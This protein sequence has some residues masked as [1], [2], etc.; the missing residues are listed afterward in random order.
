MVTLTG[1]ITDVTGRA[2]DSISSITVKA[3]SARIGGGTDVIVSSPAKVA[4]DRTTGDV[5]ISGLTGGLSWLYIEGDGWSDSIPLA[6][7]EGFQLILEAIANASGVPGV[8]DYISM[9]R[10]S[11]THAQALARAAVEGEFG[12]VVRLTQAAATT[13][14]QEAT[15]ADARATYAE[16][17]A[18]N[19]V[20]R[21]EALETMAGLAPGDISDATMANI[22]LQENSLFRAVQDA[23]VGTIPGVVDDDTTDNTPAIQS[24]VDQGGRWM[25]PPTTGR[26]YVAGEVSLTV[27]GTELYAQGAPIRQGTMSLFRAIAPDLRIDGVDSISATGLPDFSGMT[28]PWEGTIS[29]SRWCVVNIYASA[30]RINIPWIRGRGMSSVV[31]SGGWDATTNTSTTARTDDINI[32][33]LLC[34]HVEFGTALKGTNRLHI[35]DIRGTYGDTVTAPRPPHLL[36]LAENHVDVTV[37]SA[38]A[39]DGVGG[40][41]HQIKQ[42]VGGVFGPLQATHCAGVLNL[43]DCADVEIEA[44]I[45]RSDQFS[46]TQ[47][48][49]VLI[50]HT[51]ATSNIHIGRVR[52]DMETNNRAVNIVNGDHI[53]IDAVDV[54]VAHTSTGVSAEYD[55]TVGGTRCEVRNIS[56][57]NTGPKAW[58][59]VGVW[60]TGA[61]NRVHARELRG[62][63]VGL[64]ARNSPDAVL[65]YDSDR[66]IVHPTDGLYALATSA[67]TG[68]AR[69]QAPQTQTLRDRAVVA[70]NF[71]VR[72][73]SNSQMAGALTGQVWRAALGMW[74][75][76]DAGAHTTTDVVR[77]RT[78]VDTGSVNVA[79]FSDITFGGA[80]GL[81]VK[82]TNSDQ[83]DFLYV[84]LTSTEVSLTLN[85]TETVATVPRVHQT[86]R[87]YHVEASYFEGV[88]DVTIDGGPV[89]SHALT[90]TQSDVYSPATYAGLCTSSV[91]TRF[92]NFKAVSI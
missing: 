6:V 25:L 72:T 67:T 11:G 44:I 26:Y 1:K 45:S 64:D 27:P 22:A 87:T 14:A 47:G 88:V 8:V 51:T 52:V 84:M 21:V 37:L 39:Q 42:V 60:G 56:V 81:L 48:G 46:E 2:P 18:G 43:M 90:S 69:F 73:G 86:G 34:A 15:S 31:R 53:T 10:S 13:A 74:L 19:A 36:Y 35:S 63:R 28:A 92:R 79:V 66:I 68:Q 49:A 82:A 24:A 29:A 59:A 80:C 41:A 50:D 16:T 91:Q 75:A 4:F 23:A 61:G 71:T 30:H 85:G 62:A 33:T 78:F 65:E 32:G 70:D 77:A 89:L 83:S 58:K 7:A 54:T 40:H 3:P 76:S 9:I 20:S 17:K 38:V 5:T 12:E 57:V 55:V